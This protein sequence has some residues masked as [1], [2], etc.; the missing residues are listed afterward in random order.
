MPMHILAR[1][2]QIHHKDSEELG[3]QEREGNLKYQLEERSVLGNCFMLLL[4]LEQDSQSQSIHSLTPLN[5]VFIF[6][7][8]INYFSKVNS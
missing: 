7:A 2:S 5:P 3:H 4:T 8:S 6:K 1:F